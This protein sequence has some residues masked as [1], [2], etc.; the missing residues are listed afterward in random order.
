MCMDREIHLFHRELVLTRNGQL[1]NELR[2]VRTDD[3]RTEDL[4]VLRVADDLHEAVRLAGR[5]RASARGEVE[6]THLVVELLFLA[7][8]LGEADGCDLRMAVR[9]TR[10]VAIV[11][12]V[13]VL[14]R[15]D[16]G[17]GD[18]LA[19]TLVREHR[20]TRDVADGVDALHRGLHP[21]VDLDEAALRELDAR[22]LETDFLHVG[23]ATRGDENLFYLER[24][25]LPSNFQRHRDGALADLHVAELRARVD[26]DLALAEG[27]LEL[28]GAIAV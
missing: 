2:G 14:A 9:R 20:G 22:F 10:N 11:H 25:L 5:S 13:S 3:V 24:F 18:A 12:A 21:L 23:G 16:L 4:S 6:A 19:R 28:F 1:V 17:D 8:L 15:E 26:V 7:L 27:A